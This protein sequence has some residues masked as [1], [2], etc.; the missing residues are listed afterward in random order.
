MLATATAAEY[1]RPMDAGRTSPLLVNCEKADGEI[2]AVVAKFSEFCDQK[3]VHLAREIV[4]A[5]LAADLGLPIPVPFLVAVPGG[6]ADVIPDPVRQAKVRAS[7]GFAFG[8]LLVTG[9]YNAWTPDTRITAGMIDNATAIFAFDAIIQN[10]DRRSENPNC[11]VRGEEIRIFD[12]ELA[13]A[14]RLIL[15]WR[16]PWTPGGLNWI[17][18]KGSH[19]FLADLKR[20]GADFAAVRTSWCAISDERLAEYRAAVPMQWGNISADVDSA[21][22]LIRDAR[23][24]IDGC[25]DEIRRILS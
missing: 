13:F 7:G 5:C 19:I 23:D 4:A 25:L 16:P 10:S 20:S 2:V 12:H 1:V 18:R 21:L 8:S 3:E 11:L 24:N 6:W 22:K 15:G 9:G 14:H 17:E